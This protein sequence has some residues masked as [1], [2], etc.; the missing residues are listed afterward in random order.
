MQK[1]FSFLNK[2]KY[3]FFCVAIFFAI[4]LR[5]WD[6]SGGMLL[7]GDQIRDAVMS[8]RSFENGF[9]ELPL[10]GPRAGGTMLRLGPL[11]YYFQSASAAIFGSIEPAVLALPN[12]LFSLL[13]IPLF[14]F[15]MRLY[16][17]EKVSLISTT[18]FSFCFLAFEYS[19][20]AWNPNSIPFFVLL[21]LYAWL[22]IFSDSERKKWQWFL[23]LGTAF[24]IAS[25]LHFTSMVALGIFAAVFL[26]FR[27]KNFWQKVGWINLVV[28]LATVL[29]FYIPVI[30][31]DV[32]SKGDNLDLFFK[33]IGS[34]TSDH[35]AWQNIGREFY[36]F[37]E[38][39]F[40]IA[41]GYMG[42]L[43]ILHYLGTLLLFGGTVLNVL[44]LRQEKEKQKKDFLF[45]I[46]VWTAT[47]FLLY[48]PL[49]YEIDK[50]RFFLPL[51]FLPFL[52]LGLLWRWKSSF[53]KTKKISV[54]ILALLML[55][56][57]LT[58]SLLWLNEFARAQRGALN[59]K[60]TVILKVKK[61]DAWWTWGMIEK[62]A[63][64]MSKECQG[65]AIYYYLPKQ[66]QEFQDVFEWAFKLNG[67]QRPYSFA[68]KIDFEKKGCYFAISKQT[69]EMDK[70]MILGDFE[71][72]GNA[73][74]IAIY[75]MKREKTEEAVVVEKKN[76]PILEDEDDIS[77]QTHQ[78]L[79]WKDV[80]KKTNN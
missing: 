38:Y 23:L 55:A 16:F 21:F 26:I 6:F 19:R 18:L 75:K 78:R 4:G 28:F 15:L 22:R 49:A 67:K 37:G 63:K 76:E 72:T 61:D 31:S 34:K 8:A 5:V 9:G 50:P 40:R 57:N 68:K 24:A 71:K 66:S 13:A 20:F 48:F 25:Q 7:K 65:G 44:L 62:T 64:I 53:E 29:F 52:H 54:V 51:M 30:V 11:F 47:F 17:S 32:L 42:S 56:G 14:F 36:Y 59:A 43:K 41:F 33:S 46:L 69:Y 39:Y 12:L 80:F 79:Y 1:I 58:A 77:I 74:D 10:L 73:G 35:T 70:L 60:N 3:W 2:Y 45:V 27:Y